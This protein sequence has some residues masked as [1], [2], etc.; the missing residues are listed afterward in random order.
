MKNN[1][2]NFA[3]FITLSLIIC[4]L[5]VYIVYNNSQSP[6]C[7]EQVCNCN[8]ENTGNDKTS[9]NNNEYL[10]LYSAT[11]KVIEPQA[12]RDVARFN[13]Y[14]NDD[15]TF[16]YSASE[17]NGNNYLGNYVIRN[18]QIFLNFLFQGGH[19]ATFSPFL[20]T[21]TLDIVSS[22]VLVDNNFIIAPSEYIGTSIVELKRLNDEN[23]INKYKETFK[24]GLTYWMYHN[25]ANRS[26][27]E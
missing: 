19:Q 9:S 26:N 6:N 5:I 14:L 3:I 13:L 24:E 18:N 22:D 16:I 2:I 12:G 10:G 27:V 7:P 17:I 1:K 23:L 15:G 20:F 25:D 8:N 11:V 21:N 4:V